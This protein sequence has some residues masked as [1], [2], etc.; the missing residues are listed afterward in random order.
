MDFDIYITEGG[1]W[2][3]V[4]VRRLSADKA[5]ETFEISTSVNSVTVRSNR[6]MLRGK[7]LLYKV[8]DY[9]ILTG[10]I[11]YKDT[12]KKIT[13]AITDA[14]EDGPP[15]PPPP[16][17]GPTID[18]KLVTLGYNGPKREK[19]EEHSEY[20]KRCDDHRERYIKANW[21]LLQRMH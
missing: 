12:F 3:A 4:H 11:R 6:P 7:Q 9:T 21:N 16:K 5:F 8:P 20:L 19:G 10:Q 18:I 1:R 13:Y 2:Y 15:A 17:A 14:M